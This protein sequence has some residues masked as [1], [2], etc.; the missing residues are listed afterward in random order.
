[1][2]RLDL[3]SQRA[4]AP[5]FRLCQAQLFAGHLELP[6]QL[7]VALVSRVRPARQQVRLIGLVGE[8]LGE[9]MARGIQP[10]QVHTRQNYQHG[11]QSGQD[12][13]ACGS[14]RRGRRLHVNHLRPARAAL[15]LPHGRR[16]S[17][18][19]ATRFVPESKYGVCRVPALLVRHLS[20]LLCL[21]VSIAA[22]CP[23]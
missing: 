18:F 22:D 23:L 19:T 7:R 16:L 4:R 21:E 20:S 14:G 2:L 9:F 17:C 15:R 10:V 11:H 6:F 8:R 13:D 12:F 3:R 5:Q 1:M